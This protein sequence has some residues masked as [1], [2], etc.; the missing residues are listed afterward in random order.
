MGG[1]LNPPV[2]DNLLRF[3]RRA[4]TQLDPT[5]TDSCDPVADQTARQSKEGMDDT[6]L[7]SSSTSRAALQ[8]KL[9]HSTS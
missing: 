3:L 9:V 6:A 4:V 1:L 5:F 2:V 8:Q 7:G